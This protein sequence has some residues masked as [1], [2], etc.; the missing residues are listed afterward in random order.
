MTIWGLFKELNSE[1]R[2]LI[3]MTELSTKY[4]PAYLSL[5]WNKKC[6]AYTTNNLIV[7]NNIDE[8][9]IVW[10]DNMIFNAK[11]VFFFQK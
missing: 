3:A 8:F 1:A 4:F 7:D 2:F 9:M 6:F 10:P 11:N 5:I